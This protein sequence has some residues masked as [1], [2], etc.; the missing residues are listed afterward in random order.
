MPQRGER[1]VL[2]RLAEKNAFEEIE[3][4]EKQSRDGI[5]RLNCCRMSPEWRHC[6]F[7]WKPTTFP[8]SPDRIRSAR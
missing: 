2:T 3:R 6:R 8:T 1:R 5:N 4:R 7:G